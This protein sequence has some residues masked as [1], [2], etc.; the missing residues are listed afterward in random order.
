[1]G[2]LE[3]RMWVDKCYDIRGRIKGTEEALIL[4]TAFEK[5][6][7]DATYDKMFEYVKEEMNK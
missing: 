2:V 3:S 7:P 4:L 1:V 5:E 6:S